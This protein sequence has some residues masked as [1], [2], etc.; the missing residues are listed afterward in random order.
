MGASTGTPVNYTTK[1]TVNIT[2]PKAPVIFED[3]TG[4]AALANF[5]HRAGTPAKNYIFEVPSGGV[6]IFDYDGDGLPDIYFVNGSTLPA[7]QGKEKPPRAALYRNLGNWKFEDVTEKAGVADGRGG[8][9]LRQRWTRGPVRR[10]FRRVEVV[11]QQRRRHLHRCGRKAGRG[12]Q[13]L[14]HRRELRRL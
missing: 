6:A 13:R 5:K 4:K 14:E 3:V 10:E 8:R 11:S 12:A 9:R 7:M 1:R 2:D